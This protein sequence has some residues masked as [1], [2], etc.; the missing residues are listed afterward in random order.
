MEYFPFCFILIISRALALSIQTLLESASIVH[1]SALFNPKQFWGYIN[2]VIELKVLRLTGS[3]LNELRVNQG[4]REHF[5]T[6]NT[7]KRK[8]PIRCGNQCC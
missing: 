3:D 5:K 7:K 4:K 6:R 2:L 8:K 1:A